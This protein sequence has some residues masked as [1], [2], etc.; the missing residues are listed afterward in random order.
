M[1]L[2]HATDQEL[3]DELDGAQKYLAALMSGAPLGQNFE[4]REEAKMAEVRQTITAIQ[5]EL[6]KRHANRT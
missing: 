3:K 5:S 2:P 4:G 6:D 1:D